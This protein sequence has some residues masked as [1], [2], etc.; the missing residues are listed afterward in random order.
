MTNKGTPTQMV[1]GFAAVIVYACTTTAIVWKWPDASKW[2][3]W[4]TLALFVVV[5]A[6]CYRAARKTVLPALNRGKW[7]TAVFLLGGDTPA[8]QTG[9]SPA[10]RAVGFA[11]LML[12]ILAKTAIVWVWPDY[13]NWISWVELSLVLGITTFFVY[14]VARKRRAG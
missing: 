4:A 7:A 1:G 14:K 8:S 11:V 12:V 9:V 5:L 3:M 13:P 6:L 10:Q 2:I